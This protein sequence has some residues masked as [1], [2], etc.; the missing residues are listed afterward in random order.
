VKYGRAPEL[1]FCL[2]EQRIVVVVRDSGPGIPADAAEQV[3][4]L[5]Y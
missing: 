4:A 1:E 5:F 3:F 2:L